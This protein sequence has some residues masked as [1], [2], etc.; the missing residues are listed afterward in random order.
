MPIHLFQS[1]FLQSGFVYE[2]ML[3]TE[4]V[5]FSQDKNGS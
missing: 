2:M 1:S 5:I 4:D 3:P